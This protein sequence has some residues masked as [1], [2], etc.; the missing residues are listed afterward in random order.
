MHIVDELY[1]VFGTA[2]K[3]TPYFIVNLP[4]FLAY[5]AVGGLLFQTNSFCIGPVHNW[6]Y[7]LWTGTDDFNIDELIYAKALNEA[8]FV[9]FFVE[10]LPWLIIQSINAQKMNSMTALTYNEI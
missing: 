5:S 1:K 4:V 8:L 6:F 3:L 2:V 7:K 10:S 9:H